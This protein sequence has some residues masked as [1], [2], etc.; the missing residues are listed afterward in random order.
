MRPTHTRQL[1]L[2]LS[3]MATAL[4]AAAVFLWGAEYK[5]SLY[6]AHPP[7]HTPVPMAK[8][9]SEKERP[10]ATGGAGLVRAPLTLAA[11]FSLSLLLPV[12]LRFR[13]AGVDSTPLRWPRITNRLRPHC[14]NHFSFRPP[15]LALC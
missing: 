15:P 11:F 12:A 5:C 14:L 2:F 13:R 9:L 1:T 10:V 7:K 4:L 6:H 3:L 8:L